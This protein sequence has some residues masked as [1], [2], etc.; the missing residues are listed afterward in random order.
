MIDSK[1]I[2]DIAVL[3]QRYAPQYGIKVCSPIIAQAILES[4]WNRSTLSAKYYNYF[5]LKCGTKWTGKS[6][7][8]STKEEYKPGVLTTIKDNFR[9]YD[10]M[11]DG[12]KGYFEFIQLE[13][14]HNLRGITDPKKYLET[15]KAD[16]YAT[17]S[18][19]VAVNMT[20][21]NELKLTKYDKEAV[22]MSKTKTAERL[23]AQAKTWLGCKESNG[24]HK[25][26]IDKYNAH[27]PLPRGY[28]VKYTDEWCAT[29]VSACA[30]AT[31]MDDIIPLEC[32]CE[33][34]I[35]IAKKMGIW[36]EDESI[37]PEPGY[38][39]L[40]DWQDTGKG[41][42]KGLADHIG[43]VYEVKDGKIHVIE[44]NKGEAVATR[45]ISINARYIR[46]YVAPKYDKADQI[47]QDKP[48]TKEPTKASDLRKVKRWTGKV[49]YCKA[50]NVRTWGGVEYPTVSFSPLKKGAKVDVCD[51][52]RDSKGKEWYYIK[53]K[54]RYGFVNAKY[55][56]KAN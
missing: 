38:I 54:E 1:F 7:N 29:F 3:V 25:K 47:A 55:I 23:I 53:Y 4:A 50:L 17:A 40:Y 18:N 27:K 12:V 37:K 36:I 41:D 21:I 33:Q 5:G 56:V 22:D 14:Y 10:S 28:A 24:S 34:F 35:S 8:L 52:V 13:R 49:A 39:I 43:I 19:Y 9:V 45:L 30:I 48:V 6:V 51:S 42:D 26:I 32:S 31:G 2:E 46:G 20:L 11:E 44:G 16:G 15:I